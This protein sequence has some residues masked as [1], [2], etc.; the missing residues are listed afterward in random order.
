MAPILH[1]DPLQPHLSCPSCSED[2]SEDELVSC[3]C[4]FVGVHLRGQAMN[5]FEGLIMTGILV[6]ELHTLGAGKDFSGQPLVRLWVRLRT[7]AS[8]PSGL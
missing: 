2:A 4:M 1:W 8:P 6:L 7:S 5:F 3:S